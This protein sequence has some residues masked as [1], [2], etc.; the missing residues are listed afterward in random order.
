VRPCG[1]IYEGDQRTDGWHQARLGKL[2]A[3]KLA[4]IVPTKAGKRP[5]S[6]DDVKIELIT[7]RLTGIPT[8]MFMTDAMRWGV[9]ME[10]TAR[11]AYEIRTGNVVREV[12]FIDHPT[13]VGAGASPDGL[14]GEDG[15]LEIKCPHT[16]THFA[17]ILSESW[18]TDYEEQMTMQMG[19]AGRDWNDFGSFDSRLPEEM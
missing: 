11:Q 19:C 16:K 6:W 1:K 18:D 7:E 13:I 4:K 17:T 5:S 3:S 2:T 9:A 14:V 15:M 10:A 8:P 12:S